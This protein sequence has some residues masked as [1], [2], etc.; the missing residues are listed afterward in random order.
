MRHCHHSK[1]GGEG[2]PAANDANEIDAVYY[3][4][5]DVSGL[6]KELTDA[7]GELTRWGC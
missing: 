6:S 4:H 7:D 2:A 1:H 3:F 5:N